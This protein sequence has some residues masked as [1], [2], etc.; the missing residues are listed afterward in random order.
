MSIRCLIVEDEQPAVEELKYLLSKYSYFE[1]VDVANNMQEAL[2]KIDDTNFDVAFLDIN[3]PGGSGVE[4]C[5]IIK[6]KNKEIEIIF[7][8]AYEDYALNAF[9]YNALDY[10]LKPIDEQR[11]DITINRIEERL[12][13]R[14]NRASNFDE[15][16]I[17]K[18]IK[19]V[20]K[21]REIKIPCEQNEKII[22]VDL[23]DVFYFSIEEDKT[24]V[25]T[26]NNKLETKFT[27]NEL[28]EMTNFLRT[29]RSFLVNSS[30]VKEIHPWFNGTYKLIMKD[31]DKSEVPV[32][33]SKGKLIKE[34]YNL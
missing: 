13:S 34:F 22:L 9:D 12:L 7:I 11:F 5:K 6:I 16:T 14:Q 1:I 33:R 29:H 25:K 24:I 3:I 20:L 30:K 19:N 26:N 31:S 23:D 15:K 10:V 4:L 17:E 2:S 21:Q 28:E 18:T 27:L 8:T 32:S